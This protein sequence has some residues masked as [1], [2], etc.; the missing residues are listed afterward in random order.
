MRKYHGIVLKY[1]ALPPSLCPDPMNLWMREFHRVCNTTCEAF[2]VAG[3]AMLEEY[4]LDRFASAIASKKKEE[5][6]AELINH[7]VR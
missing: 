1:A 6:A 5:E 3:E 4:L 2:W 7:V